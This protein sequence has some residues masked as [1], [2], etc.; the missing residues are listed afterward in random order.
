M[1][2]SRRCSLLVIQL[3]CRAFGGP[4]SRLDSSCGAF[5]SIDLPA[6]RKRL[7]RVSLEFQ[8]VLFLR[9]PPLLHSEAVRRR[10]SVLPPRNNNR[11][12]WVGE[13]VL[14]AELILPSVG[15]S[16]SKRSARQISAATTGGC[17]HCSSLCRNARGLFL[18]L[19]PGPYRVSR[20]GS[21]SLNFHHLCHL[22]DDS[23]ESV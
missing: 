21:A 8:G 2:S 10:V 7:S 4:I 1:R 23:S 11:T 6:G 17:R 13:V 18:R 19:L 16:V 9:N 15:V 3:V 14:V 20:P 5:R 12:V 22:L